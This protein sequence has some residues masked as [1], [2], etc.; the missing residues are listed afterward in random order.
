M[1]V[2]VGRSKNTTVKYR[3]L[4][5]FFFFHFCFTQGAI[6]KQTFNWADYYS[7]YDL[8]A[9]DGY[10]PTYGEGSPII[11]V[12]SARKVFTEW[13]PHFIEK[14]AECCQ[15]LK[16]NFVRFGFPHYCEQVINS[17]YASF[18]ESVNNNSTELGLLFADPNGIKDLHEQEISQFVARSP[19]MDVMLHLNSTTIQRVI[20]AGIQSSPKTLKSVMQTI[21]EAKIKASHSPRRYG[22]WEDIWYIREPY[23]GGGGY[24]T[25]LF[26]CLTSK[27]HIQKYQP[28]FP[29]KNGRVEIGGFNS[30]SSKRGQEIFN[31]LALKREVFCQQYGKD[32]YTKHFDQQLSLL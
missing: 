15:R 25:L 18:L 2:N 10:H 28:R 1:V 31:F 3:H 14:N 13:N 29:A 4:T 5:E 9:G 23:W 24:W 8:N 20:H 32:S 11:A 26:C 27:F 7:Y 22:N 30:L 16:D 21:G 6:T 12:R 17:N 19:Y